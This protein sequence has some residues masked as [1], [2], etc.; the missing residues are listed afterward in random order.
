M[1]LTLLSLVFA[2]SISAQAQN[3]NLPTG[4]YETILKQNQSKW[5]E[6]DIILFDAN[7]YKITSS[8]EVGE[9]KY[10][11]T[12]QRIIFISGPLKTVYAKT[13]VNATKPTIILPLAE[14]EQQG[15]KLVTADVVAH[16]KN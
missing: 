2:V 14:N 12:A 6:G 5:S 3:N 1:K 4:R 16:L 13:V 10:S 11:A 15:V 7:H 8:E 9:Y